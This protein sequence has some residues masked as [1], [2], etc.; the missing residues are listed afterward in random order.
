MSIPVLPSYLQGTATG[1]LLQNLNIQQAQQQVPG[2]VYSPGMGTAP[3]AP[4]QPLSP[5]FQQAIADATGPGGYID[6]PRLQRQLGLTHEQMNSMIQSGGI[7]AGASSQGPGVSVVPSSAAPSQ[8]QGSSTAET[9]LGVYGSG[10]QMSPEQLM[11][12]TL[13]LRSHQVGDTGSG[14]GAGSIGAGTAKKEEESKG[15][16]LSG[17][18]GGAANANGGNPAFTSQ[19]SPSSATI[20]YASP[21]GNGAA[22]SGPA[23]GFQGPGMQGQ[24]GALQ[25]QQA[26]PQAA[27]NA[28]QNT[29]GY[30]LMN[31]PGAYQQSP[32]YQYAMDQALGQVQ[33]QA[34]ARGMLES[35][36]V[37]RGMQQTAT[38]LAQ[39][40]Y[41]NWWNRQNQLYGDYQNRLQGLA[42]G[43]T[44]SQDA[45]T[46][47]ANLA[48]GNLQTASNLGS[49]F[50]NQGTSGMGAYVN[51]AAA[52]S[53]NMIN[54]G[55]QQANV[56]AANQATQL[57]GATLASNQRGLF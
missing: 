19:S 29:A 43:P 7:T 20:G 9:P 46:A 55:Q 5:Q 37:I 57:A 39:Q 14:G 27:L 44:G 11:A 47:G 25:M 12:A 30:Q 23:A 16:N 22:Y 34:S 33:N 1:G 17:T 13:G 51:T 4:Q 26:N 28:Y 48:S 31:A 3:Y 6:Y 40:D 41:G 38:G 52:Q 42:G 53:G 21:N 10:G 45:M 2:N 49:L 18:E 50:G 54:A 24:A 56:Q 8:N 36:A 35:G 15:L 32:G